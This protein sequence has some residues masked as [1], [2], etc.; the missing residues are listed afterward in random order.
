M[1]EPPAALAADWASALAALI[2][3]VERALADWHAGPDLRAPR[4][5]RVTQPCPPARASAWLAAQTSATRVFWRGRG[6]DRAR[7]GVGMA[8]RVPGARARDFSAVIDRCRALPLG[9]ARYYGGFAFDEG[10]ADDPAW[11]EFGPALFWLPRV[12]FLEPTPGVSAGL[13][14]NLPLRPEVEPDPDAL[15][16][17]LRTLRPPLSG[18]PAL[19][20]L[21]ERRDQP[22]L[23]RWTAMVQAALD[24]IE[25][26]AMEKV[27]LAR[28]AV[29]R[30]AAAVDPAAL[31]A[32]LEAVT[33]N[34][35]HFLIQ[36]TPDAALVST[37]PE[38]LYH[39]AGRELRTEVI[40]G[41]RGRSADAAAD[42]ALGAEL[43]A[44]EKDQR[45]HEIVRRF[46]RQRLHLLAESSEVAA[47]AELLRLERKQHL[48]S[49]ARARLRPGVGD[50]DLLEALHPTPAVGGF[51]SENARAEIR[52][53][54]PFRRGW[55]AAPVGWIGRDA[56]EFAVAIRSGLVRGDTVRVYSGAGVVRGSDPAGEWR[57]IEEKIGDFR[58][59]AG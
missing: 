36:P 9:E 54:E 19:P 52:R 38:R 58:K 31:H 4:L 51:P 25:D 17:E 35:F 34:C 53:L 18:P 22:D 11:L 24:L 46:L 14:V 10:A 44:S 57:E 45:E 2:A 47:E 7:A 21:R 59:V 40:A 13:A 32:R 49:P 5:L 55:Y 43:L 37:T 15:L 23:P 48:H 26:G 50:A 42:A 39:R 20:A 12:E 6:D 1:G 33:R 3:Q 41:T 8:D 16:A 56:A 29:H 30:F 27:V 28:K